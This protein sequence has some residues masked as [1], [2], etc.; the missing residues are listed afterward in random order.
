MKY[1]P[2]GDKR[3]ALTACLIM[4]ALTALSVA[5]SAGKVFAPWISQL[6]MVVFA[7]C[8]L[9]I[10]LKYILSDYVYAFNHTQFCID[11]IVGKRIVPLGALDLTM[12]ISHVMKMSE[13][14]EISDEFPKVE[15]RLGYCKT[16]GLKDP[17]VY[18]FKFNDK[19]A[20]LC[21]EPSDKFASALNFAIDYA[22]K[23]TLL[24]DDND[25]Y[26]NENGDK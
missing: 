17:Y 21:F 3:R 26:D 25:G 13:Y 7:V 23:G 22:K 2:E 20:M 19:V 12:S 1:S 4:L 11:K 16:M 6:A 15:M 18:I 24:S 5:L 10:Y 14:K 9:Q 8:A